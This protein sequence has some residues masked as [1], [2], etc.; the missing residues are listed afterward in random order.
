MH[1][2][3]VPFFRQANSTD[4]PAMSRIRLS[5]TENVLSDP[6]RITGNMYE[7][8][9]EKSGRGWVAELAGEVVGF[10]Y[11]DKENA[12]IWALFVSPGKE[13]R[14][15]ARSLLKLAVD[16]L[17]EIGFERVHLS[18]G[19]NTR[20][21]RFYAA[22]GWVRNPVSASEIAYSLERPQPTRKEA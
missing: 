3:H 17:F 2:N 8:F 16:W 12:S 5:V 7:D 18:T 21:D 14:G 15:L 9:L 22:Q 4:I 1:Q 11:A 19:A 20:A 13:G 10:C 6:T